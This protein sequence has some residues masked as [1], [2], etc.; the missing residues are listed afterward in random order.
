M[1]LFRQKFSNILLIIVRFIGNIIPNNY[2]CKKD[3][4]KMEKR[5]K[6]ILQEKGMRMSELASRLG[7]DQSNLQK[8]LKGNPTISTLRDIAHALDIDVAEL[9][10]VP[11][12][13]IKSLMLVDGKTYGIVETANV[14]SVPQYAQVSKLY[15]EVNQFVKNTIEGKEYESIFGFLNTME[16]FTLV[17][18]PYHKQFILSLCYGRAQT[19]T[20]VFDLVE[21]YDLDE[22]VDLKQLL[23]DIKYTIT[24]AVPSLINP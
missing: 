17:Y 7:M 9:F 16:L 5:I 8:L 22:T 21:Y 24:G 1:Q 23:D 18:D 2:L 3:G 4:K 6:T 19:L 13:K 20:I 10:A 12:Q 15:A 11:Q 14:V